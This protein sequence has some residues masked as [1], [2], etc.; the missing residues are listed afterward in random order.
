[1]NPENSPPTK[2][3]IYTAECH[4]PVIEVRTYVK[5]DDTTAMVVWTSN[6]P[7][8]TAT[9]ARLCILRSLF[10][11][12]TQDAVYETWGMKS[13][14]VLF[15]YVYYLSAPPTSLST[16]QL[17]CTLTQCC[18]IC[19]CLMRFVRWIPVRFSS[20][21]TSDVTIWS[22]CASEKPGPALTYHQHCRLC[23][24]I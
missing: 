2:E 7:I 11:G 6:L 22:L 3:K 10:H 17:N 20:W 4:R 18:C 19:L 23:E 16:L 15:D 14:R 13:I 5:V 24:I 21:I 9:A 1:M 8:T 12:Q